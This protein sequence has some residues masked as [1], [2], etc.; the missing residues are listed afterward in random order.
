MLILL[1]FF[2]FFFHFV[3][4][5]NRD[6][7]PT[8][9]C[10]FKPK[11][12]DELRQAIH[13]CYR[14]HGTGGLAGECPPIGEWDVSNIT[15]MSNMF[16]GL[17]RFNGDL[18]KWDVSNVVDMSAMFKNAGT[19]TLVMRNTQSIPPNLRVDRVQSIM[20]QLFKYFDLYEEGGA[21]NGF[22]CAYHLNFEEGDFHF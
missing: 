17:R 9:G 12:S 6:N 19:R 1:L 22:Y 18:S 14:R 21:G 11:N 2:I 5:P 16:K 8:T 10:L 15:D 4:S 13:V 20:R 3:F 7:V